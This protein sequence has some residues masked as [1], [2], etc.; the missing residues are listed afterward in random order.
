VPSTCSSRD[1]DTAPNFDT[2]GQ[3]SQRCSED[4]KISTHKTVKVKIADVPIRTPMEIL[5]SKQLRG[6]V[7]HRCHLP[8]Q[9]WGQGP[10]IDVPEDSMHHM[11]AASSSSRRDQFESLARGSM[12][13][14]SVVSFPAWVQYGWIRLADAFCFRRRPPTPPTPRSSKTPPQVR[15]KSAPSTLGDG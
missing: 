12:L 8:A 7:A 15:S 5:C 6:S 9:G 11:Q 3:I 10:A 1:R 4:G 13:G 2:S 14:V